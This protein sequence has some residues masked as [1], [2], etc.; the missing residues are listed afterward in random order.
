MKLTQTELLGLCKYLSKIHHTPGRLRVRVSP[1]IKDELS[2]D[3]I[4]KLNEKFSNLDAISDVKFNAIIGSLT[5]K[6][7]KNKVEPQ[8]WEN[9]LENRANRDT[10]PMIE[11]LIGA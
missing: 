10:L 3:D 9:L 1:K 4:T 2:N 7:D 5:I 8:I 6:Y 11:K